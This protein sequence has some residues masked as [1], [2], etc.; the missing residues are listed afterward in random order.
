VQSKSPQVVILGVGNILLKDE[1]VGI[2]VVE[3]LRREYRF[4]DNVRLVDGATGGI[5]LLPVVCNTEHLIIV[6]ALKTS[7][8][9]G[10]I[11]RL[12]PDELS[13]EIQIKCSLHQIGLLDVLQMAKTLEEKLPATVIV[14]VEPEDASHYGLELTGLISAKIPLLVD[15]I[16]KELTALN[17]AVEKKR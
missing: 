3:R 2:R 4:P 1:G 13:S 16:L 14:G 11:F 17:V 8:P 5:D 6:D 10:T 15:I 7:Q 12:T 9:P